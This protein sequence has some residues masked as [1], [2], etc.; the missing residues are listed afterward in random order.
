MMKKF[1]AQTIL[2]SNIQNITVISRLN[3]PAK[4]SKYDK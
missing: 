4:V 1:I 2:N 3:L